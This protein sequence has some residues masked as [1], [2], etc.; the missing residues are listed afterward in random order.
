MNKSDLV[1][2]MKTLKLA[3]PFYVCLKC[4]AE[5][6][7]S[8]EP[9]LCACGGKWKPMLAVDRKALGVAVK[10]FQN[11]S[12]EKDLK[13]W[14]KEKV[15]FENKIKSNPTIEQN[16]DWSNGRIEAFEEVL[17]RLK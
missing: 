4:N 13:R 3:E 17:G 14:L 2:V 16:E 6:V 10:Q 1:G 7:S 11:L 15:K 5:V 12:S 8:V 9:G